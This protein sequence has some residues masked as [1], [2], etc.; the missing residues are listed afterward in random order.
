MK[1]SDFQGESVPGL[2]HLNLALGFVFHLDSLL[3]LLGSLTN[4]GYMPCSRTP[5]SPFPGGTRCCLRYSIFTRHLHSR[6]LTGLNHFT[7]V[8]RR[9]RITACNLPVYASRWSLPSTSQDSVRR[10]SMSVTSAGLPVSR[11]QQVRWSFAQ[12]THIIFI[13]Y[14]AW[15]VKPLFTRM[16]TSDLEAPFILISGSDV[17]NPGCMSQHQHGLKSPR[18]EPN[19]ISALWDIWPKRCPT[20]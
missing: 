15:Y 12:R 5:V 3:D 11:F 2:D 8:S 10:Y 16:D 17:L 14:L 20:L 18:T 6:Y 19:D 9:F 4:L 7:L 1:P 13:L